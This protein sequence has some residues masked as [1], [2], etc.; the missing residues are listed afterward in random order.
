MTGRP[1]PARVYYYID[2]D[3][4]G[5]AKVLVQLR[6]DVTYPGDPGGAG[7]CQRDGRTGRRVLD[8]QDPACWEALGPLRDLPGGWRLTAVSSQPGSGLVER[9]RAAAWLLA[10]PSRQGQP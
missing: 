8:R 10:G 4:L 7:G 1:R 6:G 5:V 2:A 9:A 3:L